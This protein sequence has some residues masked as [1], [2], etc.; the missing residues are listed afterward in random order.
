M[1]LC[2]TCIYRNNVEQLKPCIVYRDDCNLYERGDM[3]SDDAVS[4]IKRGLDDNSIDCFDTK[5]YMALYMAIK[6]LEQEPKTDVLDKIKAGI[7]Q[8]ISDNDKYKNDYTQGVNDGL[9]HALHII[10]E[11]RRK[12]E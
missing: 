2:D 12:S 3:T 4:V 6:A 1:K 8:A 9:C 5:Q 11:Y 7:E 10:S